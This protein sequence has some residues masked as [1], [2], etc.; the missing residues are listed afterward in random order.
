MAY[1]IENRCTKCSQCLPV[2][3][4]GAIKQEDEGLWIDPTRCNDCRG[5]SAVPQCV[6]NCP[7]DTP[8]KLLQA[9]KGRC[10]VESKTVTSPRLFPNGKTNPFASAIV[11]W[12]ACNMLAQRQAIA[13]EADE[14]GHFCYRRQVNGGRGAIAIRIAHQ[15]NPE[16]STL[17]DFAAG[18]AAIATWDV[19]AACLHL[20][21]AAYATTLDQAWEQGFTVNDQ[22]ISEYLGLDKRKDLSK[23]AK[24][25]LIKEW[26]EQTCKLLVSIEWSQQGRVREI[27]LT[28]ERIWHLLELQYH[29]QTDEMDCKHLSGM[30]FKIKAGRWAQYLLN[31]QGTRNGTAFY[32]YG[33]LPNS[34][35]TNVMSIWQQHEGAARMMFWLLF[36]TRIGAD[37]RITIPTLMRIGYGEE[38]LTQASIN[39]DDRKRLLRTFESDLEI[40]NHYH[41]KPIF[42]P[43]TYPP[44][45]QPL[46]AKLADL[47]DDAEAALEFWAND[48]SQDTRLT[49]A[50]PRDK[51][52]RLMH[53]RLLRFDLPEDWEQRSSKTTKKRTR[54]TKTIQTHLPPPLSGQQVSN[55][56]KN[57]QLSQRALANQ[58]GK[59]QSWVRDIENGRL[60]ATEK[61]RV[62]LSQVLGFT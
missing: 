37:Q 10:K 33:S 61:D 53:A 34:L 46:W 44:Q 24:L 47:P 55:A 40:L 7:I 31:K 15:P 8:P 62:L 52:H 17:L 12:E 11:V 4:T 38:R 16:P 59:S 45:I 39:R 19:R 48:G 1:I 54:K 22:Q 18:Q 58:L 42:D 35:L 32:Q 56:R 20:I 3:P 57:L 49:D 29:F 9:K 26:V 30:T 50:A 36:K 23:L 60:Q 13:A 14:T 51:W 43:E 2:C 41:L 25:T 28:N 5:F 6:S 27:S 21:F